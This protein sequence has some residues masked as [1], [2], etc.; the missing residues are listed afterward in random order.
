MKEQLFAFWK[1][2]QIINKENLLSKEREEK[3]KHKQNTR[4]Y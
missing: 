2:R 3:K 4:K 1:V